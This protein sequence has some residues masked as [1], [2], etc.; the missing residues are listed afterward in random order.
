MIQPPNAYYE[1]EEAKRQGA[2]PRLVLSIFPV[3]VSTG[4]PENEGTYVNCARNGYEQI[5]V[6]TSLPSSASWTSADKAVVGGS[7]P[8]P[9]Q[10]TWQENLPNYTAVVE[11]KTAAT[12]AGL[13]GAAYNA[14]SNGGT[15]NLLAWY[16]IRVKFTK[17]SSIPNAY[18]ENLLFYRSDNPSENY[19]TGLET[20][21]GTFTNCTCSGGRATVNAGVATAQ[22]VGPVYQCSTKVPKSVSWTEEPGAY[23]LTV[24]YRNAQFNYQIDS[25]PWI[26]VANGGSV[27][28]SAWYF[29]QWR[30]AWEKKASTGDVYLDRLHLGYELQISPDDVDL[31]SCSM[32]RLEAP[33]DFSDIIAAD[34]T[35]V[36]FDPDNLYNPNSSNF[37]LGN[38]TLWFGKSLR[39]YFGFQRAGT[40]IIDKWLLFEGVILRWG[41]RETESGSGK[42]PRVEIYAQDVIRQLM[43]Q[44]VAMSDTTDRPQPLVMGPQLLLEATEQVNDNFNS[45]QATAGFEAGNLSELT[46]V[47]TSGNGTVAA[48]TTDPYKGNY[49]CRTQI[50]PAGANHEATGRLSVGGNSNT[51]QFRAAMLVSVMPAMPSATGCR[52]LAAMKSDNTIIWEMYIDSDAILY[53]KKGS[54]YWQTSVNLRAYIGQ[55]VRVGF[56]WDCGTN[57]IFVVWFDGEEVLRVADTDLGNSPIDRVAFG[58]K[59]G[60]TAEAWTIYW[61]EV[62]VWNTFNPSVYFVTGAPYQSILAVYVDGATISAPLGKRSRRQRFL[63]RKFKQSHKQGKKAPTSRYTARPDWGA[64]VW[65]VWK[66]APATGEVMLMVK[67]DD[68]S[69]PVNQLQE[70]FKSW[71]IDYRVDTYSFIQ[72]L[73]IMPALA[74]SC[75]F[76]DGTRADAIKEISAASLLTLWVEAGKIKIWATD[77]SPLG[78]AVMALNPI[79]VKSTKST[80]DYTELVPRVVG[81]WGWFDRNDQLIYKVSDSGLLSWLGE[82]ESEIDL[83][84][85]NT[86]VCSDRSSVQALVDILFKLVSKPREEVEVEAYL[87]AARLELMDIC[88][89]GERKYLVY[90][91]SIDVRNCIV[92]LKLV[93]FLGLE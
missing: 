49:C 93:R 69:H 76:D 68:I 62:N 18:I 67:H 2:R 47:V 10:V 87:E 24:Y 84:Y 60:T 82:D 4:I 51:F 31:D 48:V 66:T 7:P 12:Q 35:A 50:S 34:F 22:W 61:D 89:L 83:S 70:M 65:N 13:A 55:W 79:S 72:A 6:S 92:N 21:E 38:E 11:I 75:F 36:L 77:G 85:G 20:C 15:I 33:V 56:G 44:P 30:A 64:I 59:T 17:Q 71:G 91:K 53:V 42:I 63:D 16:K 46:Q 43:E 88:A 19:P 74:M 45:P 14:V 25:A 1:T 28:V 78:D 29:Y 52:L 32:P 40:G 86:V 37:L 41:P 27:S 39:V 54:T 80:L 26:P 73:Q 57:D 23:N 58:P 5:L 8:S 90:G 81:K 9:V 3:V